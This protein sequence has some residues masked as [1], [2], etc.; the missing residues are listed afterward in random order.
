MGIIGEKTVVGDEAELSNVVVGKNCSIG[1]GAFLRQCILW[2]DVTIGSEAR[3]ERATIASGSI[4]GDRSYIEEGAVIGE[5]CRI[6]RDVNVKPYVKI[7]P[8]KE[9]EEG[10]TVSRSMVWRE[11]WSRGIFGP[12]GVTGLCNVE[13]TPEFASALGVA[14]GSLLGKGDYIVTSRD[15]H[16]SSRMIYRALLSGVLSAGVNVADLEMVPI[17]VNRYELKALK[18]RGGFHVRKSPYDPQ[19]IDLKFFDENGRDLSSVR[20]KKVERL[21]FGEDFKRMDAEDV[22]ELSFPFHRIV[23]SYKEG[24]LN[25]IDRGAISAANFKVVVDYAYGSASQIFPSILGELGIEVIAL[26]AHLD[27]TKITKTEA[28]FTKALSQLSNI[29]K[30]LEADL[31]IMLDTGAEKIFLC[32]EKGNILQGDLELAILTMLVCRSIRNANIAVPIKASRVIDD[33]AK[34]H[35]ARVIRTKTSFRDMSEVSSKPGM[36]FLGEKLGGFIF[37]EF[38]PAFDAMFTS[39][40]LLEML[41]R[42][43]AHLSELA[44]EVPRIGVLSSVIPCLPDSKGK[45]LR[46]LVDELRDEEVDLTDGIKIFQGEDWVLVLPDPSRPLIHV[47]AEA[48]TGKKAQKLLAEYSDKIKAVL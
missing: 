4:I 1:R 3:L 40:K 45:I 44:A 38:Q 24:M 48:G 23:E 35:G 13:I 12:Y 21:F 36:H 6:G 39:V 29:V 30:S 43:R 32:D 16:K 31:G 34:K 47:Y 42:Q 14:F 22:G 17:P 11:R 37:P 7:W 25:W 20:E 46:S 19:V 26:N 5:N 33:I 41:A 18:S 2:D 28:M 27:E 10:A 9:I 15:S 8:G